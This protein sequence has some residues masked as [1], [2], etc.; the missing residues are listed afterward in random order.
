MIKNLRIKDYILIDELEL[1]LSESLN[2][3][4]G[5]TGAGKS[6]IINAIDLVFA[7]RVSKE[8]IK[9]GKD[10]AIIELTLSTEK[11]FSKIFDEYG[12]EDIGEEIV[13]TKE[14]SQT[15]TKTR[16][17]GS[18]ANSA[19]I[20]DMRENLLDI[21]SQHQ[22]YAFLQPKYHIAW[23]DSYSKDFYGVLLQD[24]QSD[25]KEYQNLQNKLEEAKCAFDVT[26]NQIDFLKFQINEISE[27][28]IQSVDEVE[29]LKVE[30]S[31][32]ENVEKLKNLTGSS[33]WALSGDDNSI[34][35]AL[36]DIKTNLSKA[37]SL[38][39][40][41]SDIENDFVNSVEALQ[42]LARLLRDYEQNLQNDTERLNEVQER[43]FL[44]EKLQRK[45]GGS[46]EEVLASLD[47][48]STELDVIENSSQH[49][50]EL[51]NKI[52]ALLKVLKEKG[53]KLTQRRKEQAKILADKIVEMLEVLEL[54]KSRFEI[55]VETV[56]MNLNGFDKVEFLISTNVSEDL[57]PL[58]KVASGGELSRVM[59]AIKSI[60]AQS[61]EIETVIFDEID[62]GISG[63]T[64]Q[65]VADVISNFSKYHQVILITHQ[66]IIAS[67]ADEYIYVKKA[68]DDKTSVCVSVLDKEERLKAI[69]ELASGEVSESSLE[70]A[71]SLN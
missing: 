24:F 62:T 69:A 38:D 58:A 57:K 32:L 2:V 55:A 1:D 34:V 67:K 63:K 19:V 70:F 31:K 60:F 53:D 25:F 56:E 3:I 28:N 51:E 14:I 11:D 8:V 50:E 13:I 33:H 59:L 17:N 16:I 35:N 4:T 22:T 47:K 37:S 68:Q 26:E 36:C 61:D 71:K 12:I 9:N 42:E 39:S 44:L 29:E 46:L 21:H 40:G 52:S 20:K 64:S 66:P 30:L 54:P 48:F 45:Y 43:L 6:I 41:L 15:S 5:E 23:L 49:V 18:L 65:S 7:P 10:K 27:A